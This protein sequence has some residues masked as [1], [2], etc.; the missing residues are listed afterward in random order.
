MKPLTINGR[1]YEVIPYGRKPTMYIWASKH[2]GPRGIYGTHD[3]IDQETLLR[4]L[5][6]DAVLH[7]FFLNVVYDPKTGLFTIRDT[8]E[9]A[10]KFQRD[11]ENDVGSYLTETKAAKRLSDEL[12]HKVIGCDSRAV[13]G[14]L[15]ES[16][17]EER[18]LE[19]AAVIQENSET[20]ENPRLAIIGAE[21]CLPNSHLNRFLQRA[22]V[23]YLVVHRLEEM[24]K[25][26]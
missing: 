24:L 13:E 16:L 7:E 9:P 22:S 12:Q 4:Q 14:A 26:I 5:K 25:A 23:Q 20:I 3:I 2:S 6:P 15:D 8:N 18:E 1:D 21:H 11:L 17:D 10:T 19:Q